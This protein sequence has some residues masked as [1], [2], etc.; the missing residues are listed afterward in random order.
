[1]NF[2]FA[3]VAKKKKTRSRVVTS[4]T[5]EPVYSS[6]KSTTQFANSCITSL[7]WGAGG[8]GGLCQV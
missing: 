8:G 4:D 3:A 5:Q 7:A 1:M 2:S 6:Q